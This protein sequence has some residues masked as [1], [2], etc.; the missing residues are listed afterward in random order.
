MTTRR[1]GFSSETPFAARATAD[2]RRSRASSQPD[3]ASTSRA[4]QLDVALY[5]ESIAAE[6]RLLARS[7]EMEALAYFLEMA[8]LEASIQIERRVPPS[9]P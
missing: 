4:V 6:L 7:A 8:R 2:G 3:K 5:I 1:R 9:T